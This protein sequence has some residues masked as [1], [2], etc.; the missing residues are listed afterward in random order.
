MLPRLSS[1]LLER[2]IVATLVISIV[3]WADGGFLA[4]WLALAPSKIWHGQLWRLVTWPAVERGPLSLL[5]TCAAIFKF[6]GELVPRWGE[7]RVAR[8]IA[9]IVVATA[10]ATC[11][12]TTLAGLDGYA[13]VGGWAV[14]D[15]LVIA[16][17]RQFPERP[18]AIYGLVVLRGPE[19]IAVTVG[20]TVVFALFIGPFTMAPELLACAAAVG[21]P[22][23][24]LRR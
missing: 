12:V 5:V 10:V 9:Q 7:R 11:V 24:L 3:A 8:F 4:R 17:A 6:G 18:I 23:H 19:L 16:W 14:S 20:M 21:Y 15:A 22:D 2:W 1:R 13:R